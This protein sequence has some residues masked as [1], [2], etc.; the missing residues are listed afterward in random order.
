[1]EGAGP[2]GGR[3]RVKQGGIAFCLFGTDVKHMW[4][5]NASI[6]DFG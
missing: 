4:D 5:E 6:G 1:M 3:S 2:G